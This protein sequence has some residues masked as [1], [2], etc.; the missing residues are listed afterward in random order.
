MVDGDCPSHAAEK[1]I[2]GPQ[3]EPQREGGEARVGDA[4]SCQGW[5]WENEQVWLEAQAGQA[6][7]ATKACFG[8]N[9]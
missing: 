9:A 2:E 5:F 3:R 7:L 4:N 6:I 8:E 1:D